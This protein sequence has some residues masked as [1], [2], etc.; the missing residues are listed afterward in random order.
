MSNPQ[1]FIA[2]TALAVPTFIKRCSLGY[3]R[4]NVGD[5]ARLVSYNLRAT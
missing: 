1:A 5:V 3:D 2:F 4:A